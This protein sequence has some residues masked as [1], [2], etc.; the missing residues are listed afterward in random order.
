MFKLIVMS[1]RWCCCVGVFAPVWN[2][3]C[4]QVSAC[5]YVSSDQRFSIR[6]SEKWA[7][8][9][10]MRSAGGNNSNVDTLSSVCA[11]VIVSF[12]IFVCYFL[13]YSQFICDVY[14]VNYKK[15]CH[16]VFDY[17]SSI[18]WWIFT[19]F[20]PVERRRNALQF[21]YLMTWWRHNS[22]TIHVTK[23]YLIQLVLKIK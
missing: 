8:H 3:N 23:F 4:I 18:S 14:T 11:A 2:L 9:R 20:V 10:E 6:G 16:F 15:T 7:I 12:H 19:I 17:N 1:V 5:F 22:I 21:S 13:S